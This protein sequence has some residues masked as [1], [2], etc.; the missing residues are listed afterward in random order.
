MSS[1]KHHGPHHIKDRGK[2]YYELIK[3]ITNKKNEHYFMYIFR[4]LFQLKVKIKR[5]AC[6]LPFE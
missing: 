5:V 4:I 1:C 6:G 2:D 3:I